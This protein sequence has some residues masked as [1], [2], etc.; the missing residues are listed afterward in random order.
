MLAMHVLTRTFQQSKRVF[1]KICI[2]MCVGS[3]PLT[4]KPFPFLL[5]A[6]LQFLLLK[7]HFY[8]MSKY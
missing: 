4:L 7:F 3:I 5:L 8:C 1:W 2:K 6:K